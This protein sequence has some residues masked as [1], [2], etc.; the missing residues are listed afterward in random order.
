MRHRKYENKNLNKIFWSMLIED[1]VLAGNIVMPDK[2]EF[3]NIKYKNIN[4]LNFL[5]I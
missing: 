5:F 1:I 3:K 2:G 4:F